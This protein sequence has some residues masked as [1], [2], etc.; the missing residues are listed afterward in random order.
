MTNYWRE[1][2]EG[3]KRNQTTSHHLWKEASAHRLVTEMKVCKRAEEARQ[4]VGAA[5]RP[6]WLS[7]TLLFLFT[8]P[9][10]GM[11]KSSK[12]VILKLFSVMYPLRNIL[13]VRYPL[14]RAKHFWKKKDVQCCKITV[15]F[16]KAKQLISVNLTN[17]FILQT[18]HVETKKINRKR[19]PPGR[20]KT[21]QNSNKQNAATT[22]AGNWE[23]ICAAP[24]HLVGSGPVWPQFTI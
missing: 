13:L 9:T 24:S 19:W 4:A 14:A 2:E 12:A 15:G 11:Q 8:L 18:L 21:S 6:S 17:A 22:L 3:E 10:P 16:I 23:K 20:H 5:V 7:L 1:A